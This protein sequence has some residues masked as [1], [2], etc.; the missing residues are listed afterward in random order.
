M[1]EMAK[2]IFI[3]YQQRTLF[4]ESIFLFKLTFGMSISESDVELCNKTQR[5]KQQTKQKT[6]KSHYSVFI[7]SLTLTPDGSP[8]ELIIY[9]K[10]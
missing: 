6:T 7:A 9:V 3:L 4:K 2:Y 10:F 1:Q 8:Q 5:N